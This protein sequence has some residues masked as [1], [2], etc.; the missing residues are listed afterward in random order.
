MKKYQ[1][2]DLMLSKHYPSK[3]FIIK[4]AGATAG[5]YEAAKA[6]FIQ[7]L[8]EKT[9]VDPAVPDRTQDYW[10]VGKLDLHIR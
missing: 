2:E 6:L 1:L 9:G 7:T 10:L 4:D 3:P 5:S 8:N